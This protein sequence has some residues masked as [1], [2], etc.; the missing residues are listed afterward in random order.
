MEPEPSLDVHRSLGASEY[1]PRVPVHSERFG[2]DMPDD[3]PVHLLEAV[4]ARISD[5]DEERRKTD[6]WREWAG[7]CNGVLYRFKACAE[8]SDVLIPSLR[9]S[10]SP[11]LPERYEQEKL[12]FAF[13]A[14]GLS[15]IE[16]LYYGIFFIGA[17]VEPTRVDSGRDKGT[18]SAKLV[19]ET[20][21]AA[22]PGDPITASLRTVLDDSTHV[23]WRQARNVLAHRAAPGRDLR[24]G[25]DDDGTY[26]MGG[27]LDAEGFVS[28]RSWLGATVTELLSS[29]STFVSSRLS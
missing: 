15:A 11:P 9:A 28:R 14:E 23:S 16:C 2:F 18:I 19:T 25:G 21:K 22:F 4:H 13:F 7:A 24:M 3:F 26:W 8:H 1:A 5:P 12:L 17:L 6:E 27:T 20:Y 29:F 10:T